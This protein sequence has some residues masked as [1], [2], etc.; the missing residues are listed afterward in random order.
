[1]GTKLST[2]F[3][4]LNLAV[5]KPNMLTFQDFFVLS[6]AIGWPLASPFEAGPLAGQLQDARRLWYGR[7]QEP[8]WH[9]AALRP[10]YHQRSLYINTYCTVLLL[11]FVFVLFMFV[12]QH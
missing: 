11:V 2:T 12:L 4:T 5:N 3:I 6:W 7:H 8:P 1:M 9:G 10:Q